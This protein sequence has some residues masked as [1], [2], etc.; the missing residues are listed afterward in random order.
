MAELR[1]EGV[2]KSFRSH[3]VLSD[4]DLVVPEGT[5]TA[6]LGV[7]GSG[8]T[9][10]LRLI[11]GFTDVDRGRIVV[12]GAT[13]SEAGRRHVAPEK[14]AI[15]YV[16][17]EGALYPHLNVGDNVGFGLHRQ[18]RRAARRVAEL[19]DLVG[20]SADFARRH[21]H[22]L[23][24]G[25]QRRVALARALAPRPRLVLLDEP[26]SGLD[27]NLRAETRQA[28]LE[29]LSREGAT[30]V[31]V[32][33]DQA[34]ALSVGREVAVLQDGRLVQTAE[35]TALYKAPADLDVARFV[36]DAVVLP[37]QANSGAVRC[38][39]GILS[40]VQ[41]R[42]E[43]MVDVVVRPEQI[44]VRAVSRE[45][46]ATPAGEHGASGTVT[47]S[48]FYGAQTI[49]HVTLG[50]G[51]GVVV[52]AAVFSHEAPEVGE[53]VDV[54]VSG[55]VMTYPSAQPESVDRVDEASNRTGSIEQVAA[56]PRSVAHHARDGGRIDPA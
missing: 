56:E 44:E 13:V 30:G 28:V 43:G 46:A 23:S 14:R 19:L 8:K 32:T 5:L 17:Q 51:D 29:A 38:A 9:T 20:L 16:A 21:P 4:V 53:R 42:A 31:L 54:V 3:E 34:E 50:G 39:L 22:E 27:P 40:T 2:G 49:V 41:C 12:A 6:I 18:E 26:F 36:G 11:I 33:H 45:F 10:L 25:E 35:P 37:G 52:T 1:C 24:G 7:S 15:G 55:R 47:S 48:T